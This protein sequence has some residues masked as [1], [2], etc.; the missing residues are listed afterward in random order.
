MR[1]RY[2]GG[3]GPEVLKAQNK[4]RRFVLIEVRPFDVCCPVPE[5]KFDKAFDS[6]FPRAL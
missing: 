2:A 6:P 3:L 5:L 1:G 4:R